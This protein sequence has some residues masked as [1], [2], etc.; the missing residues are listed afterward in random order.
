MTGGFSGKKVLIFQQRDWAL[1][2]GRLLA[3]KLQA[4]GCELAALTLKKSTHDFI[5][6]QQEVKYQYVVN[7]DE[8]FADPDK[9]LS[10]DDKFTL[11]DVCDNL[12]VDSVWALIQS[13][14]LLVRSYQE[15]YYYSFSQHAPDEYIISYIRAYY[16][17]IKELLEKFKPDLIITAAAIYEGHAILNLLADRMKVPMVWVADSK[18][19]GYY[20][21]AYDYKADRGEFF[22]RVDALNEKRAETANREKA[23]Q[24]IREFRENFLQQEITNQWEINKRQRTFWEKIKIEL[25]PYRQSI[26]WYLYGR[27]KN[28]IKNIGPAPDCRPP[29]ILLRDFYAQKRYLKFIKNYNYFPLEEI[30]K[31]IFYPLQFQPEATV[32][33]FAPHFNN[34]LEVAR[35]I[36]ISLP[37]DYTLVV[38]MHPGMAGLMSPSYLK[39]LDRTPNVKLVDYRISS[40]K[41]IKKADL[42]ISS[43]GTALVEA[44]FFHKPAIQLGD[45]GTT[46]KS[47]NVFKHTDMT[48]LPKKI[49]ELLALNLK[50]PEFERK[51]ENYVA[52]VYDVGFEFKY[53]TFWLKG[54]GYDKENFW[55]LY[56]NE[57]SRIFQK[58]SK[59]SKTNE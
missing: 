43:V 8:I 13:N 24:Y 45:L 7:I 4:E 30:N 33:L 21:F 48:T 56:R 40:E 19:V 39:K 1:S 16:K 38:K 17:A 14:R 27:S 23:K 29:R 2:M 41:I 31:C 36:A 54:K 6:S 12:G 22:D 34:Q 49:K 55:K 3:Q 15:K 52:A 42:V 47:P 32:D 9:F 5:L 58:E 20:F 10:S 53:A 11:K 50:T 46:L 57:I 26:G 25:S 37:G 18:V 44:A 28:L 59:S 35:Q 51:L